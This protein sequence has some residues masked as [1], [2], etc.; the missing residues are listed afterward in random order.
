MRKITLIV[1]LLW[2]S[3][4]ARVE[5]YLRKIPEKNCVHPIENV[6]FVYVINLDERP[7]KYQN[8][9]QQLSPYG[10]IPYRFSAVNGWNLS[11]TVLN[12][13][14]S[15]YEPRMGSGR[16]GTS[17]PVEAG[18]MPCHEI[19]HVP[20]KRY[21]SH[22]MSRGAVG[23]LLSHLSILKDAYDSGYETIWVLEDDIEVVQ[24]P[25]I[26]SQLIQELDRQV[27]RSTWD[28]LFTD[29]DTK[30]MDGQYVGCYSYAWRP[31][32]PA[33]DLSRFNRRRDFGP[34]FRLVG[35]RY[36][37]YSMIVRRSGMKKILDF[38]RDRSFFLPF[39]MEYTLPEKIVLFSLKYDV[40]STM[41][42]AVSDNGA[43][44]YLGRQSVNFQENLQ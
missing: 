19:M 5:D 2:V 24:D 39:D 8:T 42:R 36:G 16:W 26:L 17:Y 41:P 11:L 37:A 33:I 1:C 29:P 43:P 28:I 21:Y 34:H 40:V 22:C 27:G 31:D 14:A 10:I 32:L 12:E 3:L 38:F 4:H 13:L 20:G 9:L 15:A 18:G 6:D 35:A 23:I 25:R 30:G 44:N 7:E